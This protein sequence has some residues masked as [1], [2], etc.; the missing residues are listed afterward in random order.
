[1]LRVALLLASG[2]W[3]VAQSKAAPSAPTVSIFLK[4]PGVIPPGGSTT[5]CCS[6]QCATGHLVLLKDGR[7]LRALAPRGGRAEFS[8]SNATHGDA[9]VYSCQYQAGGTLLAHSEGLDV[10]VQ[11][12]GHTAW[13]GG[14]CHLEFHLP[15]P[16]LSVLPWQEVA[17]GAAV[18][19]RCSTAH[20]TA[21]C[22]LYLQGQLAA[23]AVLSKQQED[24]N[25]SHVQEA[26]GGHYSCQCFN[27]AAS[28]SWSAASEPLQLVVRDYT[29]SNTVQLALGAGVLLLLGLVLAEATRSQ[30]KCPGPQLP[31][32][33]SPQGCTA[34]P[35]PR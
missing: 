27:Q 6:C 28:F 19:L 3:L 17:A 4:P 16:V 1:M 10:M 22:L 34:S 26:N 32:L 24:F 33:Q 31:P 9:G 20:P 15:T 11:G 14:R 30:R 35:L 18:S 13:R 5:I 2:A 25:I 8:I 29:W 21:R 12:E 23:L 7:R